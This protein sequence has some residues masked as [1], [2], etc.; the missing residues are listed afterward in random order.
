MTPNVFSSSGGLVTSG[1]LT[2]NSSTFRALLATNAD[3]NL[4]WLLLYSLNRTPINT[5]APV[6][7]IPLL[8]NG[9]AA[10]PTVLELGRDFFGDSGI[11]GFP[12]GI[13]WAVSGSQGSYDGTATASEHQ[14]TLIGGSV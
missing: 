13:A 12:S 7:A 14:I 2:G 6:L 3:V 11:A 8:G 9:S 5:D 1:V 4:R 10:A